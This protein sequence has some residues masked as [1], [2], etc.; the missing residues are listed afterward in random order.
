M[1]RVV[2]LM[3]VISIILTGCAPKTETI[4]LVY[5]FLPT[6]ECPTIEEYV[7]HLVAVQKLEEITGK[8]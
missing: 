7:N 6:G 8:V 5:R 1:R 3:L 2:I 4:E